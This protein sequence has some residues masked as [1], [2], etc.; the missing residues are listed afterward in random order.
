[1]PFQEFVNIV[2]C[3]AVGDYFTSFP[4]QDP[5]SR[6][7][8]HVNKR[9]TKS[10]RENSDAIEK[11]IIEASA[12]I[13]P[14]AVCFP[15]GSYHIDKPISVPSNIN[16][17]GIGWVDIIQTQGGEIIEFEDNSK[18]IKIENLH[19]YG[20]AG[21]FTGESTGIKGRKI[22]R[23]LI[24]DVDIKAVTYGL[25]FDGA[26]DL[27]LENLLVVGSHT[28]Y[29]FSNLTTVDARNVKAANNLIGFSLN[30]VIY[31]SFNG[32]VDGINPIWDSTDSGLVGVGVDMKSCNSIKLH[33]GFERILGMVFASDA[34][35]GEAN[36]HFNA[37]KKEEQFL[38]EAQKR[39]HF[40]F[41]NTRTQSYFSLQSSAWV[42]SGSAINIV[43]T[44]W[45]KKDDTDTSRLI[46]LNQTSYLKI[47][48]SFISIAD[49]NKVFVRV[50]GQSSPESRVGIDFSRT[51]GM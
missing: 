13:P 6:I 4:S 36:I 44:D 25:D 3:G 47:S 42:F 11:A 10:A 19:L 18:N 30:E 45:I 12:S 48:G 9:P 17:L 46:W 26:Y 31:S 1:M 16:L 37:N 23:I 15:T 32:Y 27:L 51:F 7:P 28:A 33:I 34:S 39:R 2:D 5:D 8:T 14:K 24:R 38:P 41:S 43:A 29:K 49:E 20:N 21:T 50:A 22:N 40:T 35:Y